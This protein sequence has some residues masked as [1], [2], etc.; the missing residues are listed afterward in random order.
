LIRI[1]CGALKDA[2]G[3]QFSGSIS[4][5]VGIAGLVLSGGTF[6]SW[7]IIAPG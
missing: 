5:I 3:R 7:F 6:E 2:K 1:H 4:G